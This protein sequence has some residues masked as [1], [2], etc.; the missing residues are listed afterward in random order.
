MNAIKYESCARY[1]TSFGKEL[2]TGESPAQ[3]RYRT[4]TGVV[5]IQNQIEMTISIAVILD[6]LKE[7]LPEEP[8]DRLR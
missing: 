3:I 8:S 5:V 2:I 1:L 7:E 4:D 6:N